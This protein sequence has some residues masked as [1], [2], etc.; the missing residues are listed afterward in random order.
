MVKA[1]DEQVNPVT[2]LQTV[3][4]KS[5]RETNGELL[6]VDWIGDPGWTTGSDH[7]VQLRQEERFEVLSG[8]LGLRVDDRS[9]PVIVCAH[10]PH[11]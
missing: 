6:G 5:A 10:G 1:G 9:T 2:R 7:S 4:R 8:K 3:F 11:A